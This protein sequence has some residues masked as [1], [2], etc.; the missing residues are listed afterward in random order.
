MLKGGESCRDVHVPKAGCYHNNNLITAAFHVGV[1]VGIKVMRYP[2]AVAVAV[3]SLSSSSSN[4]SS[5]RAV[6]VAVDVT[7]AVATE[8]SVAVI[9]VA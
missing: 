1:R 4:S 8:V 6:A 9:V 5:S 3:V 2:V 7:V